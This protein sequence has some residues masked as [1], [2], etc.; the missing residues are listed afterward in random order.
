[1]PILFDSSYSDVEEEK[2]N[3]KKWKS[4]NTEI[5]NPKRKRD[6]DGED[7]EDEE[8]DDDDGII[9]ESAGKDGDGVVQKT[10]RKKKQKKAKGPNNWIYVSGLPVDVTLEEIK[11]HFSKVCMRGLITPLLLPCIL[12]H[13]S[14]LNSVVSS[15]QCTLNLTCF[16]VIC[17][18][19]LLLSALSINSPR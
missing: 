13:M 1:L 12:P 9:A 19:D 4:K 14:Y 15:Y 5:I 11:D 10:K 6:E 3:S 7:A 16:I 2:T 17:R 8:D 18:W